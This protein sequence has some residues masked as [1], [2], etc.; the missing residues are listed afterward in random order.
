MIKRYEIWIKGQV[1]TIWVE[2][3]E[4]VEIIHIAEDTLLSGP[5][6]DQSALLGVLL[7]L[8]DLGLLILAVNTTEAKNLRTTP[9]SSTRQR[10]K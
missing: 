7:K 1:D 2:W 9:P 10:E 5:M 6:I 8:H 4:G 3:F